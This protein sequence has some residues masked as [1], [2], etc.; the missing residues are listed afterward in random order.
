MAAT[1]ASS[2]VDVYFISFLLW[3]RPCSA[4]LVL[5]PW[6]VLLCERGLETKVSGSKP[7]PCD[8]ESHCDLTASNAIALAPRRFGE[9]LMFDLK[10]A[11]AGTASMRDL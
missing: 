6:T 2:V 10:S 8:N 1:P 4:C 11:Q 5:S 9:V 7:V 3:D